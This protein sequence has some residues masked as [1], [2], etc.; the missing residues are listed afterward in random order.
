MSPAVEAWN[1]N[2]WTAREFLGPVLEV[3]YRC[4]LRNLVTDRRWIRGSSSTKSALQ[5]SALGVL[6]VVVLAA[7]DE[8]RRDRRTTDWTG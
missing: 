3:F 8:G 5:S 2:P 7:E 6:S 1:C 4:R